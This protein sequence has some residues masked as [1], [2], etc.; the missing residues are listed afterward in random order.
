M[1]AHAA[2]PAPPTFQRWQRSSI[3]PRTA[4]AATAPRRCQSTHPP[5]K[6]PRSSSSRSSSASTRSSSARR[7]PTRTRWPPSVRRA[8]RRA[9]GPHRSGGGPQSSGGGTRAADGPRGRGRR[10]EGDGHGRL[11]RGLRA[12]QARGVYRDGRAGAHPTARAES[13]RQRGLIMALLFGCMARLSQA[14]CPPDVAKADCEKA[15]NH[16]EKGSR[17]AR[18]SRPVPEPP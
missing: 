18:G 17:D 12:R 1:E 16:F 5:P 15:K 7:R 3:R 14:D 2:A 9:S 8:G 10:R 4:R 6:P 13:G 11:G